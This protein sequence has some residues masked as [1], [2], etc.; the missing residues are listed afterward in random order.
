MFFSIFTI[1]GI[2]LPAIPIFIIFGFILFLFLYWREAKHEFVD[3]GIVFDTL[4]I[5]TISALV[6]ARIFEF[7]TRPELYKWQPAN[8]FFLNPVAGLNFLG[9]LFGAI[10]AGTIYLRA[11][12]YNFWQIFDL[13]AAP[14]AL[15]LTVYN[16]GLFFEEEINFEQIA[17]RFPGPFFKSLLFFVFFWVLKRLEKQKR[18]VGFFA[19]IFLVSFALVFLSS[20]YLGK[21]G[22]LT[23]AGQAAFLGTV[24]YH[25]IF[26]VAFLL[27]GAVSW[28]I[29]AKRESKQDLKGLLALFLLIIFRLKRSLTSIS[30]ANQIARAIVLLPYHLAVV[31]FKMLQ[32][33]AKEIIAGFVDFAHALG[34]KK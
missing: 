8:F 11:K 25:A 12:K 27:F 23:S 31:I 13:A 16:L 15:L 20:F 5:C 14:L 21:I 18:H 1:G 3:E 4:V 22:I 2:S 17:N 9:A 32:V 33:I 26:A 6:S 24:S 28:Y 34:I 30:E 10:V 19:S 7:I 29:L